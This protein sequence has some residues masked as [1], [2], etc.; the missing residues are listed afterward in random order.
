M[1]YLLSKQ[2]IVDKVTI[3]LLI[4]K[5]NQGENDLMP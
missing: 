4:M 5:W 3:T 1:L 2:V